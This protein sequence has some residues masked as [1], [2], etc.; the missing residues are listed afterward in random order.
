M[1]L[2]VTVSAVATGTPVSDPVNNCKI[3]VSVPS[4][5]VSERICLVIVPVSAVIVTVP[6][7]FPSTKSCDVEDPK[8][9][10]YNTVPFM[11]LSVLTV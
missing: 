4:V 3:T 6:E 5:I 2:I 10:Q 9:F 7:L 8:F 1:S 11:M